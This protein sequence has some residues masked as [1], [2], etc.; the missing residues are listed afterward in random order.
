MTPWKKSRAKRIWFAACLCT[1]TLAMG[2]SMGKDS[3]Q[4][5]TAGILAS[6]EEVTLYQQSFKHVKQKERPADAGDRLEEAVT[7]I[8]FQ[9]IGIDE[10]SE[11]EPK[12]FRYGSMHGIQ[13]KGTGTF[14]DILS[15]F[16]AVHE[17]KNWI[18]IDVNQ[19]RR[20][21]RELHFEIECKAYQPSP[22]KGKE[23]TL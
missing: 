18:L 16:D 23:K 2:L 20:E 3:L 14:H 9:G 21:G 11:T 7:A 12:P 1:L 10:I 17:S 19:I 8:R 22:E 13:M 15:I 4:K 6:N 5:E